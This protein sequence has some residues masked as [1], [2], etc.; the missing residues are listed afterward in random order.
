M[1]PVARVYPDAVS[2]N[3]VLPP[4]YTGDIAD[5]PA[6]GVPEHGDTPIPETAIFVAH[7][8]PPPV[9]VILPL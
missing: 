3:D 4:P 2:V 1:S 8:N 7:G 6:V 5:E 9:I